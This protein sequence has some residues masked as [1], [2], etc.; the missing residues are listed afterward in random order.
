MACSAPPCGLLLQEQIVVYS[1]NSFT[2]RLTIKRS[3]HTSTL[4]ILLQHFQEHHERGT[5]GTFV[6]AISETQ[7]AKIQLRCLCLS[8]AGGVLN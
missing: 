2:I 1:A 4:N 6:F 5:H 3:S 8:V 7:Q